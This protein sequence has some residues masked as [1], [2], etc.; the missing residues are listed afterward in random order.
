M[1]R[2]KNN[3]G[4]SVPRKTVIKKNRTRITAKASRL[5]RAKLNQSVRYKEYV[6]ACEP[7][8]PGRYSSYYKF[9]ISRWPPAIFAPTLVEK[10][11]LG[12]TQGS[13][14]MDIMKISEAAVL[15]MPQDVPQIKL[16]PKNKLVA[17]YKEKARW[18][19]NPK[20]Q[21]LFDNAVDARYGPVAKQRQ[22]MLIGL[23]N[24]LATIDWI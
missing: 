5:K 9:D 4:A 22:S 24:N 8:K 13:P 11:Y 14:L 16:I 6:R 19:D 20:N 18:I 10:K 23:R 3:N 21:K 1:V 7:I 17:H 2:A 15:K 12:S